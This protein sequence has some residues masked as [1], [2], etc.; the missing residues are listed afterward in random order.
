MRHLLLRA[1]S[2][3]AKDRCRNRINP[4]CSLNSSQRSRL[5]FCD[6]DLLAYRERLSEL[7]SL[8][9]RVSYLQISERGFCRLVSCV[10]LEHFQVA[11]PEPKY[12]DGVKKRPTTPSQLDFGCCARLAASARLPYLSGQ[13]AQRSSCRSLPFQNVLVHGHHYEF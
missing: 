6:P 13:V 5:L 8:R 4:A 9:S 10:G 2:S 1:Q 3:C 12:D 11:I 7:R